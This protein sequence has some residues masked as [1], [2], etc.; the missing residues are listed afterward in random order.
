MPVLL[1]LV[2]F[3]GKSKPS[4]TVAQQAS[5]GGGMVLILC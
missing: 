3:G 5:E 2:K 4:S 1:K